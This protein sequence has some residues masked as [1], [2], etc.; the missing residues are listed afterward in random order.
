MKISLTMNAVLAGLFLLPLSSVAIGPSSQMPWKRDVLGSCT[1][2]RSELSECLGSATPDEPLTGNLTLPPVGGLLA[3]YVY[4]T[5]FDAC[6][7]V[8]NTTTTTGTCPL[9]CIVDGP[10]QNCDDYDVVYCERQVCCTDCNT[11][12]TEYDTCVANAGSCSV[13]NPTCSSGNAAFSLSAVGIAATTLV[14]VWMAT[15]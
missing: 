1:D 15:F 4:L 6:V 10:D 3:C 13:S 2:E 11:Y 5:F 14:G 8:T 12:M 7:A 9:S